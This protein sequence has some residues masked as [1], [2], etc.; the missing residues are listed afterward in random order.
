VPVIRPRL[1][2]LSFAL[3]VGAGVVGACSVDD[4]NMKSTPCSGVNCNR[5]LSNPTAQDLPGSLAVA[6]DAA[7]PIALVKPAC[8]VGSC[9]PD[10]R[11]SCDNYARS[12]S[13]PTGSGG[14]PDAALGDGG[15]DAGSTDPLDAGV[16]AGIREPLIDGSF[17]RPEQPQA[18]PS[19]FA[20]QLSLDP[21]NAVVRACGAA[22]L[23]G[24][25]E[26]CNSSTDCAPGLGCVGMQ[27]A[28]RCLPFCCGA[29]N[30]CDPGFYCA[31][32]P[33]RVAEL[34]ETDGP[35][36]PVCERADNCSLSEPVDCTGEHCV[37]GPGSACTVVRPDD[38]TTACVPEGDG[39]AGQNCPCKWGFHCS[40][41]TS[42]GTCVKTCELNKVNDCSAG[43]CQATPLLPDGWGTCVGA[44]PEQM[45]AP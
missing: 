28:G 6:A 10:N 4:A 40:Q 38:G 21:D 2:Q 15:A 16:D 3:L 24:V 33:L 27:R 44:A 36:V 5:D 1:F 31:D 26:A 23:Q 45:T 37:C 22:G 14:I 17:S 39:E 7:A 19:A 32:R 12:P 18:A 20:C 30:N 13:T 9:L 34:G 35:L 8:G 29:G 42:P 11:Q 43:V 25:D 41:A